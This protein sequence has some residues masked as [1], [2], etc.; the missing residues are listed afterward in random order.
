MFLGMYWYYFLIYVAVGTFILWVFGRLN[1]IKSKSL[2]FL[3]VF[4]V[5]TLIWWIVYDIVL[6]PQ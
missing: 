4:S 5:Y 6:S 3:T 1:I 2:R